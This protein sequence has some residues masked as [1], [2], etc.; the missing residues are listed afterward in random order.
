[1]YNWYN[2]YWLIDIYTLHMLCTYIRT[3]VL[4]LSCRYIFIY[5]T[6]I[7][8]YIIIRT[9]LFTDL[10]SNFWSC[11]MDTIYYI[12]TIFAVSNLLYLYS[13]LLTQ[14]DDCACGWSNYRSLQP[15]KLDQCSGNGKG[16]NSTFG[17][18]V[19]CQDINTVSCHGEGPVHALGGLGNRGDLMGPGPCPLLSISGTSAQRKRPHNLYQAI[20]S[21]TFHCVTV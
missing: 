16:F 11:L 10:S 15:S 3:Y 12:Y 20:Q 7:G 2:W 14:W 1:M 4:L 5:C 17:D 8:T 19:S 18:T 13:A 21:W 9:S 6:H